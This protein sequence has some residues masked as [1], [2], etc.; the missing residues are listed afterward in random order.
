MLPDYAFGTWFTWW[1]FF[2]FEGAKANVTAWEVLPGTP[3]CRSTHCMRMAYLTGRCVAT[4][5]YRHPSL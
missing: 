5:V 3:P 1:H 2:T 4:A